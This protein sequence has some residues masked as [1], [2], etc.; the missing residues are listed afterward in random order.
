MKIGVWLPPARAT[1]RWGWL[2]SDGRGRLQTHKRKDECLDAFAALWD[3]GFAL[4]GTVGRA[5]WS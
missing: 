3:E 2:K 4:A 5:E 1:V